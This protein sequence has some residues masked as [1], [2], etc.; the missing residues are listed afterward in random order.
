MVSSTIWALSKIDEK[1]RDPA[2]PVFDASKYPMVA[3]NLGGNV[4]VFVQDPEVVQDMYSKH[5]K[6]MDKDQFIADFFAPI[7]KDTFV[8]L[9][10]D[11]AWKTRRQACASMFFKSKLKIMTGVF[12]QYLN[13]SCDKWLNEIKANGGE[14]RIDISHE[15]ERIFAHATN[16]ICFGEDFND[17]MFDFHYYDLKTGTFIDKKVS[18]R[19]AIHNMGKLT[20]TD[21]MG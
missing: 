3:Y 15:Y 2:M 9:P 5:N 17:D 14:T 18:M 21:F 20:F 8:T 7:F 10:T 6:N 11:V 13:K 4:M 16:H 19:V 12:Q 1:E